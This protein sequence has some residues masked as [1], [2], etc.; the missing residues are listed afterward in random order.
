MSKAIKPG[1]R[2]HA[3]IRLAEQM[4]A[5]HQLFVEYR[6]LALEH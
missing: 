5:T 3:R 1:R 6:H 4:E 2:D